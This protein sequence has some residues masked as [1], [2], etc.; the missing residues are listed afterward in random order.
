MDFTVTNAGPIADAAK[1]V[2]LTDQ[3]AG[4]AKQE[5]ADAEAKAGQ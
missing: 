3:Q 2:P 1:I 4:E 5:I